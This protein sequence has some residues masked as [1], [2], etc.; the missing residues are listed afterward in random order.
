MRLERLAGLICE[1]AGIGLSLS[2][3]PL[4]PLFSH[5][6]FLLH[7]QPTWQG[8]PYQEN[9]FVSMYAWFEFRANVWIDERISPWV[10]EPI[11]QRLSE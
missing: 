11:D 2:L 10:V 6:A 1:L 9:A 7:C 8:P 3:R 5:V 4:H